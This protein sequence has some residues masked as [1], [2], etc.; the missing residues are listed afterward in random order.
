[1]TGSNVIDLEE[2]LQKRYTIFVLNKKTHQI[3]SVLSNQ[4]SQEHFRF[5]S[6]R[7]HFL[8][9]TKRRAQEIKEKIYQEQA[10]FLIPCVDEETGERTYLS[11]KEIDFVVVKIELN[12]TNEK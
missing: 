7:E 5:T 2:R 1:M 4:S 12:E 9:V 6:N 11:S 8:L 10:T 3:L